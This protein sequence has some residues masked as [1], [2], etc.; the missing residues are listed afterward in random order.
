MKT[1]VYGLNSLIGGIYFSFSNFPYL[2]WGGFASFLLS[3]FLSIQSVIIK[4]EALKEQSN[5]KHQLFILMALFAL[6][7]L[8]FGTQ[9]ILKSKR[10]ERPIRQIKTF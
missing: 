1:I 4:L 3:G 5:I 8:Y 9:L 2:L 10:D 7:C 6:F